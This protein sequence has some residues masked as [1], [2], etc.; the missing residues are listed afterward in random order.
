[1]IK[2]IIADDHPVVRAGLRAILEATDTMQVVAEADSGA[3]LRAVVEGHPPFELLITDVRMPDFD[4]IAVIER[5]RLSRPALK[6]VVLSS[7]DQPE[8]VQG[9]LNAGASG[10]IL[11]DE[12]TVK[13]ASALQVVLAGDIYL[14]PRIARV[15]VQ[16]QR[17]RS[18]EHDRL[19]QLT[20]RER[21]VLELIGNGLDNHEIGEQLTI[22]RETV[23]NHLR[24]IYDK[25]GFAHRYSAIAFALRSGLAVAHPGEE[26]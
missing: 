14:S 11:K 7:Y 16:H 4:P 23:K 20:R 18:G 22:S 6:I 5:I 13:L 19:Q 9:L 21:E 1:M 17:R 2:V 25:L 26:H 3:A 10:Y 24:N 12:L 8:Y 15:Y